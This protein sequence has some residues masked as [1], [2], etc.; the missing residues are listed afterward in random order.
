MTMVKE[1]C[2]VAEILELLLKEVGLWFVVEV[3]IAQETG[4]LRISELQLVMGGGANRRLQH[5]FFCLWDFSL[6]LGWS[7][8]SQI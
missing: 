1:G 2:S 3:H 7:S 6:R 4:K 5:S 8:Y